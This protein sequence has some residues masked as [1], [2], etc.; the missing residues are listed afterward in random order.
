MLMYLF[1]NGS[2]NHFMFSRTDN[3]LVGNL[4]FVPLH[5]H[6]DRSTGKPV[7]GRLGQRVTAHILRVQAT[8]FTRAV[9]AVLRQR[10]SAAVPH[11]DD[12]TNVIL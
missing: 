7:S 6:S 4:L 10:Y 3:G 5:V 9:A 11:Q 1:T 2:L 8:A 12:D